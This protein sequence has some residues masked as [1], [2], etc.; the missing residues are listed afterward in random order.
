MTQSTTH[1][2]QRSNHAAVWLSAAVLLCALAWVGHRLVFAEFQEYDDEGYFLLT[3]EQFLN[4]LP[5]YDQGYTWY[6]PAYYLWQEVLHTLIGLP[7]TH[8]ATRLVT[9]GVWLTCAVL[10]GAIV[11]FLTKR[12]VLTVLGTVAAFLHLAQLAFEPGHPQELGTLGV[13]G[14]LA[15]TTWRLTEKRRIG[16]AASMCVWALVAV[17]VLTKVNVGAFLAGGLTLGLVTSLSRSRLRTLVERVLVATAMAAVLLLMRGDLGRS[18]VAAYV[19]VVWCGVLAVF[20][21]QSS[22]VADEGVVTVWDLVAGV[23]AFAIAC[24]LIA[25]GIVYQGTSLRA[26]FERLF[27]APL[28]LLQL[29]QYRVPVQPLV[30]AVAPLTLLAAWC[31]KRGLIRQRWVEFATLAWAVVMFALS[32]AKLYWWL[33]ALGPLLAWLAL[34]DRSVGAEQRAARRILAFA[35]IFMGLQAYPVP[36]TQIALGT[37]LF[38]PLT[39]VMIADVQRAV[40]ARERVSHAA[41][42]SFR[43]RALLVMLA[44]VATAIIGLQAQRFYA[45][46]VP[47][48]LPGA[49]S[50]RTTELNVATYRWL[51]ANM[52]E[53]CDAFLSHPGLYSL[54]FWT[55]IAPVFWSKLFDDDQQR[56]ILASAERVERL[57]AAWSPQ[58]AEQ[59]ADRRLMAW[60]LREFESRGQFAGWQFRMRRDAP[61][62]L[63]YEGRWTQAGDLVLTLPS[64]DREAV[65]RIAIVD[66]DAERTLGDSARGEEVVALD[67][68][69]IRVRMDLGIDISKPRRITLR[70]TVASASSSEGHSVVVRLLA[71]DGRALAIVPVVMGVP[72]RVVSSHASS[73]PAG[74]S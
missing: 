70:Q 34:S 24:G 56:Q 69:G 4:G 40:S 51:S 19:V 50:V 9:I 14:A 28:L 1:T 39:F 5:I 41:R 17:T 25:A 58:P 35:A 64:I 2:E 65:T 74:P 60:L 27:I 30:A 54:H 32:A 12:R 48:D 57:C 36:G 26:L 43:R 59:F 53:N 47:L 16:P 8:D 62:N 55:E 15:L 23:S 52:R 45:R 37:V 10:V 3:V 72:S 33:F 67:E 46:G 22:D 68:E 13:L 49:R 73:T 71:R 18:E 20:I 11:W 6:G 31:W 66:V 7:V 61:A 63:V 42:V 44:M 29:S 21:T 38:V